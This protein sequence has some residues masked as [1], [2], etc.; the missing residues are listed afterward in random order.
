[1]AV[2]V[3]G[4]SV[5]VRLSAIETKVS[6]GWDQF[7]SLVPNSTLCADDELAR[8]GF[9]M[10]DRVAAFVE[11]LEDQGLAFLV[12]GEAVDLAVVDQ[13]AGLTVNCDWLEFSRFRW[14]KESDEDRFVGAC[15]LYEGKRIGFGPVMPAKG[16]S[17]ATPPGWK[18]EGSLSQKFSFT[19]Q[20]KRLN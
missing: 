15:W 11:L 3:E 4:I 6:G 14:G 8:V 2:L 13:Q 9:L 18:F 16:F 20:A 7:R 5:V 12:G 10:P 19:P 17:L 1:M